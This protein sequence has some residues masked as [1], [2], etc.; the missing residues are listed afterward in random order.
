MKPFWN[1]STVVKMKNVRLGFYPSLFPADFDR[2][3]AKTLT[4]DML[5]TPVCLA[6]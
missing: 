1:E 2:Q 3:L 4:E 6:K 5:E